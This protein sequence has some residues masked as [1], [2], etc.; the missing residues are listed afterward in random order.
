M[1]NYEFG[2]IR[3]VSHSDNKTLVILYSPASI[4]DQPLESLILLVQTAMI[5]ELDF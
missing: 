4:I 2:I 1:M 5:M 3:Q